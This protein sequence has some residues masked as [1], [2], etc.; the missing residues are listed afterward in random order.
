M[1][2]FPVQ[3]R[4]ELVEDDGDAKTHPGQNRRRGI[5]AVPLSK[6]A[7]KGEPSISPST[8]INSHHQC[9]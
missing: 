5:G 3:V 1:A 6:P 2:G 7:M 9:Y 4:F 8:L